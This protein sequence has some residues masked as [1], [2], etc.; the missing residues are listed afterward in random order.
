MER[1]E[2]C[3]ISYAYDDVNNKAPLEALSKKNIRDIQLRF[4]KRFEGRS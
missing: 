1:A 2:G 4:C 3:D